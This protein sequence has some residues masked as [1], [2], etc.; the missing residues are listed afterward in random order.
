MFTF[1][2]ILSHFSP[3]PFLQHLFSALAVLH[4][5]V[6]CGIHMALITSF[7]LFVL[8]WFFRM[9]HH[10]PTRRWSGL[11]RKDRCKEIRNSRKPG[12]YPQ[13]LDMLPAQVF[14]SHHSSWLLVNLSGSAS[15]IR[16][17]LLFGLGTNRSKHTSNGR[18]SNSI[19]INGH[20][21]VQILIYDSPARREGEPSDNWKGINFTQWITTCYIIPAWGHRK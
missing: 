2:S 11:I 9:L 4:A 17:D 20:A 5:L 3:L 19:A 13:I 12:L 1:R 6:N 18:T 8:P 10:S 16:K 15:A 21:V 7:Q 14:G